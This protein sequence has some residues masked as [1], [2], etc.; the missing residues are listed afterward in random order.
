MRIVIAED[1]QMFREVMKKICTEEF[2]HEIVGV[3]GDGE[4]AIQLVA[5]MRPDLLL[6]DLDLPRLDGFAV[7]DAVKRVSRTSRIIAVTASRA[8]YT[9]YR[10]ERAGFDGYIDKGASS[11]GALREA[12][13]AVALGRRYHSPVFAAVKEARLRDPNAFDKVLSNRELEVLSLIGLSMNDEEIGGS[14]GICAK[15]VETFRHRIL[16]KLGV[17]GTPKLI[18]FAIEKGFTQMSSLE[19]GRSIPG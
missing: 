5:A 7:A 11:F 6:L 17:R 14:L 16:K 19:P 12:L 3:V 4:A 18:R 13:A 8:S 15:T 10:V 1:E 2:G 9:L